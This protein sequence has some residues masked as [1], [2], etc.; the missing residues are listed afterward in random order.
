MTFAMT[1][2]DECD[3]SLGV[4]LTPASQP[5]TV[6]RRDTDYAS[7]AGFMRSKGVSEDQIFVALAAI[8]KTLPEPHGEDNLTR[9]SGGMSRYPV[10]PDAFNLFRDA[11]ERATNI[12][13]KRDSGGNYWPGLGR[14]LPTLQ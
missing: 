2:H 9:I 3:F 11:F 5:F 13:P 1:V 7:L 12:E 4:V 14:R 10:K 8:D 6:G